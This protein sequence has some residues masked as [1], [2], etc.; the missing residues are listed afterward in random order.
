MKL[1]QPR[2]DRALSQLNAQAVPENHPVMAQLSNLFG[3]HTFFLDAEG[4]TII[5]PAKPRDDGAGEAEKG[6]VVKLASWVD[7]TRAS[8]A[9]H[10]REYTE[11]VVVLDRAA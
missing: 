10:A 5:E 1:T 6:Q 2:L 8:L 7:E 4:L 9:P 3:D 11:I